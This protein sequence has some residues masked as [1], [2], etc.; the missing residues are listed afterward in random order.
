[1][2]ISKQVKDGFLGDLPEEIQLKVMNIHKLL[3]STCN[4]VWTDKAYD[5][6]RNEEWAKS[7]I[8]EFCAQP[9]NGT[10]IGSVRVY[11]QGKKNSCMIQLSGHVINHRNDINHELLHDFFRHV[12]HDMKTKVRRIFNMRLT[13]ESEHGEP[14]EG[15]DVWTDSKVAKVVWDKFEDMKVKKVKAMKESSAMIAADMLAKGTN[16]VGDDD[17][18]G[19]KGT[20]NVA[21]DPLG[22]D[23]VMMGES[24]N[25]MMFSELHELPSGAYN[26]INNLTESLIY[27]I[28]SRIEEP[29]IQVMSDVQ[30][31]KHKDGTIKGKVDLFECTI[32][33]FHES[34]VNIMKHHLIVNDPTKTL[35]VRE[36]GFNYSFF[37]EFSD[38]YSSHLWSWFERNSPVD[39]EDIKNN[40]ESKD[41]DD[42]VTESKEIIFDPFMEANNEKPE[43]NTDM[44]EAEAKRSLRSV[45]QKIMNDIESNKKY[46]V[47]QYTAN[48]YANIISKNLLPLWAKGFRKVT[49][50]LDD[51]QSFP[52]F[53][54]KVPKMTQDFVSRFIQ[55]RETING[56]IHRTP[57]IH[58]KMSPRIFH[59]MKNPDDAFNFFRAAIKYYDG[60]L[61][62]YSEKL[63]VEAM[64]LNHEM[65]HLIS[66]T[67]LS[68][69]ITC[70]MQLLFVFDDV[71]M[72]N[73]DT[74]KISQEDIKTVNQFIRNIYT[75]YAAP[76]KEKKQIVD[77]IRQ[78]VKA[79]KESCDKNNENVNALSYLAEAVDDYFSNKFADKIEDHNE[80]W[81]REHFDMD[82][83][84][85][86]KNPEVKYLQ[87]KFGVKK[88]KKIPADLVA[89][90]TIETEA[91]RD[92]NDKMMISSY[93][94]SKIEI[95]EWYIELLEVGSKKY[96]VPHTKPYLET[97][98]TQ[99]LA[100]FKKIM[101][102]KIVNPNTRPIIDI[103]YPNGYQG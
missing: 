41:K 66:T 56:L 55:G 95:V 26:L 75:R 47:S 24:S 32:K 34:V 103:Q 12:H 23:M 10:Q 67:K 91:I 7:A 15:F 39:E 78:M 89:Y 48:I 52:T 11:K 18:G 98:R 17:I 53:E 99:L 14:F 70:P 65:K 29:G 40:E 19:I 62:K 35:Y 25:E 33:D 58:I 71:D 63:M 37:I 68:G 64:K 42:V 101:E 59:T 13:C 84:Y 90:I 100:C 22:A 54:F 92:A 44:T 6:I 57:E 72:S 82:W 2:A 97:V 46:K 79:L 20:H 77:D 94:L 31:C 69:V 76:E 28:E 83:I 102:V 43:Y 81:I 4:D 1:M 27:A 61:E 49:I 88:L 9:T 21:D 96:V 85:H 38:E 74:F 87:E 93:C 50:S 80:K 51:Y 3:C 30:L 60:G 86:Q 16:S 45:S 36:N 5:P 8:D 73:K